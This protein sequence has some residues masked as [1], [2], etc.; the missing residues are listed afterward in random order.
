MVF[1]KGPHIH[2]FDNFKNLTIAKERNDLLLKNSFRIIQIVSRNSASAIE[3]RL[4]IRL[5]KGHPIAMKHVILFIALAEWRVAH[6]H[7]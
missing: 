1:I 5:N 2:V 6:G 4:S 7:Q 3:A